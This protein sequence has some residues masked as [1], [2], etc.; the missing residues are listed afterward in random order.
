MNSDV[1]PQPTD[2][3]ASH[4]TFVGDSAGDYRPVSRWAVAA[5][6][7]AALSLV[8]LLFED[9]LVWTL[10]AMAIAIAVAALVHIR[11]AETRPVGARAAWIALGV[12][13]VLL[14]AGPVARQSRA[15][16]SVREAAG[17]AEAWL[18]H[19]RE[20]RS[21]AAHELTLPLAIR[22][23]DDAPLQACYRN[24]P[25]RE[26]QLTQYTSEASVARLLLW[27]P[28]AT[29]EPTGKTWQTAAG[30]RDAVSIEYRVTLAR[31]DSSTAAPP[32]LLITV[33]RE[34][35]SSDG[36]FF[37][38]IARTRLLAE[39]NEPAVHAD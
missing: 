27:G 11:R 21:R 7:L 34:R 23:P 20:G 15:A 35:S 5:V 37:W 12:S 31:D 14:V 30:L 18:D 33:Q 6:I 19:V 17:V 22:C 8:T 13:V 39:E 32:K 3:A 36:R 38:R 24:E 29:Y 28:Q 25:D 26:E 4:R 9:P 10:P 16:W 1:A 2:D